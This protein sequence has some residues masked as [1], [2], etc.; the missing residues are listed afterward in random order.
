MLVSVQTDKHPARILVSVLVGFLKT[1]YFYSTCKCR[2][3]C[4]Y[5]ES[6]VY[7]PDLLGTAARFVPRQTPAGILVIGSH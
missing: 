7:V 6:N 3:V 4:I 2:S 1:V 5:N